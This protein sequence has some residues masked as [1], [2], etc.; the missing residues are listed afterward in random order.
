MSKGNALEINQTLQ[1][2]DIRIESVMMGLRT[3]EGINRNLIKCKDEIIQQLIKIT[4]EHIQTH[5]K[6]MQTLYIQKP[7]TAVH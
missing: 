2:E 5:P 1:D 6:L 4:I 3:V 7:S